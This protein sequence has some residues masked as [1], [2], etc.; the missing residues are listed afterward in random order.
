MSAFQGQ[1]T[2]ADNVSTSVAGKIFLQIVLG[3]ESNGQFES[4]RLP[5]GVWLV[6]SLTFWPEESGHFQPSEVG[7]Y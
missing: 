5:S 6:M 3:L 2:F 7:H 4:F 1:T